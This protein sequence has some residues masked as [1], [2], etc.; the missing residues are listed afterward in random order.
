MLRTM[1]AVLVLTVT[2]LLQVTP[3]LAS[4]STHTYFI[5]SRTVICTVCCYGS[6]CTTTCM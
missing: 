1:F 3:A 2:L 5:G 6:N 4:C